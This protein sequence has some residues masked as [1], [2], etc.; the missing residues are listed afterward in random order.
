MTTTAA[1]ERANSQN[2]GSGSY[3]SLALYI[4]GEFISADRKTQ[5]I[6]NPATDGSE[7]T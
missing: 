4:D 3:E 6:R 5:D 1:P 7:G 2:A